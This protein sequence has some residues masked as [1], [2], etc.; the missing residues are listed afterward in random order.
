MSDG[1]TAAIPRATLRWLDG[2]LRQEAIMTLRRRTY[3]G[4][5]WIAS[6][7]AA[8]DAPAA[9]YVDVASADIAP[10]SSSFAVGDCGD[11][12]V[13]GGGFD[14]AA[15]DGIRALSSIAL[16]PAAYTSWRSQLWSGG[17]L[18]KE[19]KVAAICTD[20]P[21]ESTVEV[22][23]F[24]ASDDHV[25]EETALCPPGLSALSGGSS[26]E[27]PEDAVF[28]A[29]AAPYFYF[30]GGGRLAEMDP[31]LGPAPNGWRVARASDDSPI[32]SHRASAQAVCR[33]EV[34]F[35]QITAGSAPAN[36]IGAAIAVCPEGFLAV[37]GGADALDLV[38]LEMV[39]SA[40]LFGTS[41]GS[42]FQRL[43]TKPQGNVEPPVAWR[44]SL[45]NRNDTPRSFQMAAVCVPE[46]SAPELV[47]AAGAALALLRFRSAARARAVR[48][49]SCPR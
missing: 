42:I 1:A 40:P 28:I 29:A 48:P 7:L 5:A 32:A 16:V 4:F 17:V 44:A 39:S 3:L 25:F 12:F 13:V 20:S 34:A 2:P 27:G 31:G 38:G 8:L 37:G 21:I 23:S 10:S 49:A 15:E 47:A 45:R 14:T 33:D 30:V 43:T 41:G 46:P 36:G 18:T 35:T 11:G 19:W 6:A 22:D 9:Y 24:N 26:S